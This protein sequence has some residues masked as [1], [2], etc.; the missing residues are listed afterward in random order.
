MAKDV[1]DIN[2]REAG[3]GV[4]LIAAERLNQI[5]LGFDSYHDDGPCNQNGE[6][7][8]AALY[9]ADPSVNQFP[10][11]W[12]PTWKVHFDRK[13]ESLVRLRIAGALIAAEIDRQLRKARK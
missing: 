10:A 6:L 3:E 12:S 1:F 4:A 7:L 13:N 9:I 11:S 5:V 2:F 8:E